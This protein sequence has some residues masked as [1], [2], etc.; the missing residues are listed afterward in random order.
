MHFIDE[1][2]IKVIAGHGGR[3]CVSFRREKYVPRGGPDG[4]N[5]GKGGDIVFQVEV[6]MST[7]MDLQYRREFKAEKGEIGRGS[8]QDG[9]QGE[10]CVLKIPPGTEIYDHATGASLADLTQ[11][12]Q[13]LVMA[14]GGRGGKGNAY[15]TTSTRQAPRHAQPGEEGEEKL[16]RLELKLLAD[17]GLIGMPNAGKSTLLS[18]ISKARPKIANY[19]FTTLAPLLG[20]VTHKNYPPFTVADIPGLIEGAHEGAGLGI[21]FLKHIERTQIFVHLVSVGPDEIEDPWARFQKIQKELTRYDPSFKKRPL[22]V[23]F[24]K[25]DLLPDLSV[26]DQLLKKF[27]QKKISVILLSSSTRNGLEE[28][29]DVLVEKVAK[30]KS[31][32]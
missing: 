15:F 10:D 11:P 14:R 3:G 4:G 20:V 18:V 24:T 26:L 30:R 16:L 2:I 5:G 25:T 19:P 7:L 9:R 27:S 29:L 17:V 28:L 1:A 6:G 12:G 21:Q 8:Q 32:S 23:A 13:R 31:V 22:L